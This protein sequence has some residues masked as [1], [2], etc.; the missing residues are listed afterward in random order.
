MTKETTGLG[1]G[2]G[3]GL[4]SGLDTGVEGSGDI[5]VVDVGGTRLRRGI[6]SAERGVRDLV[7]GPSPSVRTHPGLPVR[8]LRS[9]MV[10]ALCAAVAPGASRAGVSFGAALDHRTGT[11]YA[12]APL[13]GAHAEPFD[14]LGALRAAR[15]EV[16]WHLVNDVTAALLHAAAAPRR[17]TLRKLLLVTVS[18]GIA[19]RTLDLRTGTVP[20]DDCGLQGEIGHLPAAIPATPVPT[21]TPGAPAPDAVPAPLLPAKLRPVCD[22]G[23]PGHVAA[24]ASGPGIRRLAGLMRARDGERWA[25]SA[26]G[27]AGEEA[28]FE[29]ALREALD[30]GDATAEA[31]LAAATE[32]LAAVLRTALCLDPELDE[33][34][35]TGGVVYGLGDHVRRAL[36]THLTRTG[37]Y[38]T[39]DRSPDWA[40]RRVTAS[41]PGEADPLIGAGIAA[42]GGLSGWWGREGGGAGSVV[43]RHMGGSHMGG[44]HMAGSHM[45]GPH[46]G[47]PHTADPHTADPHTGGPHTAGC[48][49][50]DGS[51][52]VP[53]HATP[54]TTGPLPAGAPR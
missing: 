24:Y 45:G 48:P 41:R 33:I 3:T 47:G 30:A 17:R 13:W 5:S 12:S 8:E 4:E 7:D 39:A 50:D 53:A 19:C 31:L 40:A 42:G 14:L 43:G 16:A 29:G 1:T 36:L 10:D 2:L 37:L 6:W 52:A 26:L 38:L 11:V 23:E 20:V 51:P 46:M 44:P 32:P 49:T 15:P 22:C 27:R 9:R 21:A 35:L 18:T 54:G 34:V 25:A 28:G